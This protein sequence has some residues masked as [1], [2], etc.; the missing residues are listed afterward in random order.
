[1]ATN[2][3]KVIQIQTND[4]DFA[5]SLYVELQV[6]PSTLRIST[7]EVDSLRGH[8]YATTAGSS[9]S[10]SA[11]VYKVNLTSWAVETSITLEINDFLVSTS[12]IVDNLAGTLLYFRHYFYFYSVIF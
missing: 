12:A 3:G 4:N 1:M 5:N 2:D 9:R 8:L 10:D 11:V 6:A 7:V